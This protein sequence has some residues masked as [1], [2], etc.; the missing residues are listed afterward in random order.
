[1]GCGPSNARVEITDDEGEDSLV[2]EVD[3]SMAEAANARPPS[4][5]ISE[6]SESGKRSVTWSEDLIIDAELENVSKRD[7]DRGEPDDDVKLEETED[8]NDHIFDEISDKESLGRNESENSSDPVN[9]SDNE[10]VT[11]SP[12]HKRSI[13]EICLLEKA[14]GFQFQFTKS[15][16]NL[17]ETKEIPEDNVQSKEGK[18]NRTKYL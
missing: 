6:L 13:L 18:E 1:M 3:Y 2:E 4:T 8:R 5:V 14:D 15:K 16:Q 12:V 10:I 9:V 11:E 17:F 7:T